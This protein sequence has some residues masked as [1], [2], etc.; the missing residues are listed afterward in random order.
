MANKSVLSN[1]PTDLLE[2]V[3]GGQKI[4]ITKG[5]RNT[6]SA[7]VK[8]LCI[9]LILVALPQGVKAFA[10]E[11]QAAPVSLRG[12]AQPVDGDDVFDSGRPFP[13]EQDQNLA[14]YLGGE[15]GRVSP[16]LLD[17]VGKDAGIKAQNAPHQK[18]SHIH[19]ATSDA[20]LFLLS[21]LLGYLS[22]PFVIKAYRKILQKHEAPK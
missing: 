12:S 20:I 17:P 14:I 10:T 4:A 3:S 7:F 5:F 6:P 15:I 19:K 2:T 18:G 1:K 16:A 22:E 11:E 21:F 9:Y 13:A 8:L